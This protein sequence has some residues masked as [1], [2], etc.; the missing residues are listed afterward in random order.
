[1]KPIQLTILLVSISVLF[2]TCKKEET[3]FREKYTGSYL[4]TI[5][6]TCDNMI[7]N[8]DTS[9][10]HRGIIQLSNNEDNVVIQFEQ[11]NSIEP[12]IENNQHLIQ[13]LD[14]YQDDN[15]GKFL[16]ED[17]VVFDIRTGGRAA[18]MYR[19]VVG[20]KI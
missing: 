9:Y 14:I 15:L 11:D 12:K 16:N 5:D 4:F 1:M 2:A 18:G 7:A 20:K 19:H 17:N 6:V 13:K 3:D 10:S 8:C